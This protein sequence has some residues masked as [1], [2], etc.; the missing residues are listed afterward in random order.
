MIG[1]K[2]GLRFEFV[3]GLLHGHRPTERVGLA[4]L[5]RRIEKLPH[6]L[7]RIAAVAHSFLGRRKIRFQLTDLF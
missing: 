7:A 6:G 5:R 2:G 3:R 1:G 4:Y